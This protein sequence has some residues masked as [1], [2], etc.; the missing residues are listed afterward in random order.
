MSYIIRT[1]YADYDPRVSGVFGAL[2]YFL[3]Y[4][5]IVSESI[6]RENARTEFNEHAP[7]RSCGLYYKWLGFKNN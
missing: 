2:I 1:Q 7:R 6:M 5:E 3:A 4:L